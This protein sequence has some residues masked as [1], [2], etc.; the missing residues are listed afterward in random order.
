MTFAQPGITLVGES[1][2][3]KGERIRGV[4]IS[5]SFAGAIHPKEGGW[6]IDLDVPAPYNQTVRSLLR[7]PASW[8]RTILDLDPFYFDQMSLR[9]NVTRTM[10]LMVWSSCYPFKLKQIQP[11]KCLVKQLL[12]QLLIGIIHLKTPIPNPG[13][14]YM[15]WP[16][17]TKDL[18]LK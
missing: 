11:N 12:L 5:G 17:I 14:S 13:I 3:W 8:Q 18:L 6:D 10:I 7:I 16:S 9:S 15:A 4:G 2:T 1:R